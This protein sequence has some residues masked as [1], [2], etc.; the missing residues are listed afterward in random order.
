MSGRP[1]RVKSKGS[2]ASTSQDGET[3][4]VRRSGKRGGRPRKSGIDESPFGSRDSS[5]FSPANI[6]AIRKK[7]L[8]G[9]RLQNEI[10]EFD[11]EEDLRSHRLADY[12]AEHP[13]S[14]EEWSKLMEERKSFPP[15]IR[16][17]D[18]IEHD[19]T[20]FRTGDIVCLFDEDDED[21]EDLPYYAQIRSLITDQYMRP[22]AWITWLVPRRSAEDPHEFEPEH[23][24]HSLIDHKLYE[25]ES[26]RWECERPDLPAYQV[27]DNNR[28][29]LDKHR[30]E[31]FR[32]RRL[33]LFR[34]ANFEQP[35]RTGIDVIR[36]GDVK[37][38]HTKEH[39]NDLKM[40]LE[41]ARERAKERRE[42]REKM[43]VNRTSG[44]D[45]EKG[46]KHF[47]SHLRRS[48]LS[49][50]GDDVSDEGEGENEE[51]E[52]ERKRKVP[53]GKM[54]GRAPSQASNTSKGTIESASSARPM[55]ED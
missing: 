22:F 24:V 23:F 38:A 37:L 36:A 15:W 34:A 43:E 33:D 4:K 35:S 51:E 42:V 27:F 40:V 47:S 7:T 12:I 25:L 5:P 54:R 1:G 46:Y 31:Q 26:L 29:V 30:Q 49:E 55:E 19:G 9:E 8:P 13:D 14:R 20:V 39:E 10:T 16:E 41:R 28:A 32:E 17:K 3:P 52:G 18:I 48:L 11:P 45:K 21:E 44:G 53:Q 2:E 50:S 6:S